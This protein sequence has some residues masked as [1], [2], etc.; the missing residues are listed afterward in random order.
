MVDVDVGSLLLGLDVAVDGGGGREEDVD[1]GTLLNG[2]DVAVDGGG[3]SEEDVDAGSVLLG[4]DVTV[5][6]GGGSEEDFSFAPGHFTSLVS[7][8]T[9][10]INF[11]MQWIQKSLFVKWTDFAKPCFMHPSVSH[12]FVVCWTVVNDGGTFL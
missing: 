7:F 10:F 4:L 2:L 9:R 8:L 6:G 1:A 12:I 11:F 3:G 5:D